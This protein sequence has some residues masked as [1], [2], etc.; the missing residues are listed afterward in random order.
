MRKPDFCIYAKT[1]V[2]I[3][4][5]VTVKLISAFVFTTRIVQF[6]YF[7]NPEFP[8]SSHLLFLYSSVCVRPVRKPR[9]LAFSHPGSYH[10]KEC[11]YTFER[12]NALR[13]IQCIYSNYNDNF[14]GMNFIFVDFI[15]V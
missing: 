10:S 7:V 4:F 14:I 8:A 2:Q 1:K 11:T 12:Q 13:M 6:L 9:R 5:A 15:D 3:S